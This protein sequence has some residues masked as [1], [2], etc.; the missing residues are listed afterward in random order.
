MEQLCAVL[1]SNYWFEPYVFTRCISVSEGI[2][3]VD[4]DNVTSRVFLTWLDIKF[5]FLTMEIILF[6]STIVVFCGLSGPSVLS[7]R[8]LIR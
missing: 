1:E 5:F 3:I 8:L 2:S 4:L 7:I 6:S